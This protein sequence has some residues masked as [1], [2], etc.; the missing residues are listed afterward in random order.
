MR[1]II[2]L[3]LML[4]A[5]LSLQALQVSVKTVKKKAMEFIKYKDKEVSIKTY[6]AIENKGKEL[7]LL[8][9]L[10]PKGFILMS[11]DNELNP[12]IGY[13]FENDFSFE[14]APIFDFK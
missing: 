3:V 12:V 4:I 7:L 2:T 13:S 14:K 11:K 8:A 10:K 6:E 9:E 1:K 5:F